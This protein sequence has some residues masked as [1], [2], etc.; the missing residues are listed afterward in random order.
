MPT[1][2]IVKCN[3]AKGYNVVVDGKVAQFAYNKD[4]AQ[5][6]KW[7]IERAVT[8]VAQD[9]SAR[10]EVLPSAKF[11]DGEGMEHDGVDRDDVFRMLGELVRA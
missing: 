10:I 5:G 11:T 2:E 8:A 7:T 6:I 1:I 9:L 3:P 4:Q